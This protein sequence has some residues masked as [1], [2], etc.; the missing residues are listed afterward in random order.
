MA[1]FPE[2]GT[3]PPHECV[4]EAEGEGLGSGAGSQ[5]LFLFSPGVSH[6]ALNFNFLFRKQERLPLSLP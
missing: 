1:A 6:S 5:I 4:E 2:E 3:G